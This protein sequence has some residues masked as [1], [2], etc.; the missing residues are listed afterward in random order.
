MWDPSSL[1]RDRTH[2]PCIARWTL[3][4]WTDHQGSPSNLLLNAECMSKASDS[5]DSSPPLVTH[6]HCFTSLRM[7]LI[8]LHLAPA[9][10]V[11]FNVNTEFLGSWLLVW[12]RFQTLN[13]SI[14]F[15]AG[16]ADNN[17]VVSSLLLILPIRDTF[18]IIL[19]P[20]N[21]IITDYNWHV[22]LCTV[23]FNMFNIFVII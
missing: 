23:H 21:R 19:C 2:I 16:I 1:T 5:G 22:F 14:C 8:Y 20:I 11:F 6:F 17:K 12:F 15:V 10:L 3:N 9:Y 13:H 7:V 4:H 18:H